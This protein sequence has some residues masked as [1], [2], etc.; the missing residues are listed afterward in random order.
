MADLSQQGQHDMDISRRNFIKTASGTLAIGVAAGSSALQVT[1]AAQQTS[2]LSSDQPEEQRRGDMVF[3]RL[4]RTGEWVSLVGLGG[5]H[6]GKQADEND[7][8]HLVRSAIDRGITFMDNCWDYNN[9]ESEIRMGK[10]LR[11]GYREKVFLMT[12][13]DGRSKP[14]ASRQIDESLKRLQTDHID[15]LQH[16]EIIRLDDPDRV[17]AEGGAQE[18]VLEAKKAGK[19]RHIGFTGHKDP[20]MH[21]RMLQTASDNGFR[22]ETVQLPLNVMD[23]HQFRSFQHQVLP[24]L[25]KENTGVLGMK[26]LGDNF[27]VRS[28]TVTAIEALHY[29]M[30]LPTSV[31]ITGIDKPEI[32]DQAVEAVRTYKKLDESQLTAMLARTRTAATKGAFELYKTST[33]FDGTIKNPA[34]LG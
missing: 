7:S 15:L 1:A 10:A 19:I 28:N 2:N 14:E 6:M 24:V 8:I 4:G 21:L 17:F 3:R 32:L 30:S 33:H 26:P 9:G 11:D 20:F 25:V 31:V 16:H 5:Y 27:I 18:A 12:K 23:G 34:W 29:A 13:I 22:F